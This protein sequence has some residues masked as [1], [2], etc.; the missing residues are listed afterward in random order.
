[1]MFEEEQEEEGKDY[2]IG[3]GDFTIYFMIKL[4]KG[5]TLQGSRGEHFSKKCLDGNI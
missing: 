3:F 1:M 2:V 5:S 4:K